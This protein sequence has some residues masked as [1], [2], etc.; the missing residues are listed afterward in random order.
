[1]LFVFFS[2]MSQKTQRELESTFSTVSKEFEDIATPVFQ[3]DVWL[4]S[5]EQYKT[6]V[7]SAHAHSD[8]ADKL[9]A[10]DDTP[11]VCEVCGQMFKVIMLR[12]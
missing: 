6:H 12:V 10:A 8:E 5:R 11:Y 2:E 9:L 3:C 1:M 7:T 4:Q